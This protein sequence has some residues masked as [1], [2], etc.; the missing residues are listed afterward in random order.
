MPKD[1]KRRTRYFSVKPGGFSGGIFPFVLLEQFQQAVR[2]NV[3][4]SLT[5]LVE[6]VV[7]KVPLQQVFSECF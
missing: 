2:L 7:K 1:R 4:L 6:F 5:F 3:R